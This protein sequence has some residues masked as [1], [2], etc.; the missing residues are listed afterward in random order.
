MHHNF[1]KAA[2]CLM[3]C[4]LLKEKTEKKSIWK[5]V[6]ACTWLAGNMD[7]KYRNKMRKICFFL[8]KY[9]EDG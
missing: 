7:T 6:L 9:C 1:C 8:S 5:T 4:K 3:Q 2:F